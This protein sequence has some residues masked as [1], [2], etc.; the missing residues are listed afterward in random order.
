MRHVLRQVLGPERE[1]EIIKLKNAGYYIR[2]NIVISIAL[3][4]LLTNRVCGT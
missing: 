4:E 1:T 2:R 3:L